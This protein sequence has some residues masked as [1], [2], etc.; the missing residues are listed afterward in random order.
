[1]RSTRSRANSKSVNALS[2]RARNY[3]DWDKLPAAQKVE[4]DLGTARRRLKDLLVKLGNKAGR[5]GGHI[6]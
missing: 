2:L 4:P 3:L 1:M 6:K 5:A